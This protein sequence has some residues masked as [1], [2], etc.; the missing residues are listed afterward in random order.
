MAERASCDA[1]PKGGNQAQS[2]VKDTP[3][4]VM[5][6]VSTGGVCLQTGRQGESIHERICV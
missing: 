2:R 1:A 3:W 5:M 6:R 4:V